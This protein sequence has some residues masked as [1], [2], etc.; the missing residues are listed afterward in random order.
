MRLKN[1]EEVIRLLRKGAI[2]AVPTDTV[3]GLLVD[4]T[5]DRAIHKLYTLKQRP[6]E[7]KMITFISDAADLRQFPVDVPE[8]AQK[9]MQQ[10]WPGALTLIFS[11]KNSAQGE[12]STY[13][14]RVPQQKKIQELAK[15]FLP[16]PL[17]STS[18]NISGFPPAQSLEE[19]KT[20][21]GQEVFFWDIADSGSDQTCASTILSCVNH[22][23]F[24]ILREGTIKREAIWKSVDHFQE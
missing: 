11:E 9:F 15:A 13:A 5:N 10:F 7:K 3:Y 24:E 17:L 4:G 8:Y 14:F 16:R 18:A 6:Q 2:I 22:Q 1:V 23:A 21:F 19:I 20:F 12:K